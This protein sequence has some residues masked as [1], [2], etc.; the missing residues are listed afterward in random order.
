MGIFTLGLPAHSAIAYR[1]NEHGVGKAAPRRG[2][3]MTVGVAV[4]THLQL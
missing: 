2:N 1:F 4:M 3:M